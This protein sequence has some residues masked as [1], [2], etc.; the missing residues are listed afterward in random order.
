MTSIINHFAPDGTMLDSMNVNLEISGLAYNPSTKHLFVLSNTDSTTTP[1]N[2]DVTVLD[3][4]SFLC[5]CWRLQSENGAV[6]AFADYEQAG[7]EIDCNGNLW[8]V[9]QDYAESL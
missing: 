3:T 7:L 1:T 9:N 5:C 8:A 2:Y 6:K 4:A